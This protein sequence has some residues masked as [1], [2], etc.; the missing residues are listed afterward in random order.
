MEFVGIIAVFAALVFAST[1][2][3]NL[4]GIDCMTIGISGIGTLQAMISILAKLS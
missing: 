3:A 1:I 4:I 2:T